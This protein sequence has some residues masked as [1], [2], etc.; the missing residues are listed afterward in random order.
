LFIGK[1]KYRPKTVQFSCMWRRHVLDWG[2][3]VHP[4]FSRGHSCNLYKFDDFSGSECGYRGKCKRDSDFLRQ[5][6]L[7][8]FYMFNSVNC[9][10]GKSAGQTM[11][12][13]FDD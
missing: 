1:V 7:L 6:G 10:S 5:S 11:P 13:T 4:T 8:N 3:H 12:T 9:V 2:G